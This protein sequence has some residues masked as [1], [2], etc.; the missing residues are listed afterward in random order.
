MNRWYSVYLTGLVPFDVRRGDDGRLRFTVWLTAFG[1]PV[2]PWSNWTATGGRERNPLG[3][4]ELDEGYLFG[5]L[6]P[7]PW[8]LGR[9]L[10]T[11]LGGWAW[12]LS[13]VGPIVWLIVRTDGRA[14]TPGELVLVFGFTVYAAGLALGSDWRRKRAIAGR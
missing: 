2:L 7:A 14:A 4:A 3:H 1:V 9:L 10:R 12:L 8:E 6:Q 5:D 11:L 13:A